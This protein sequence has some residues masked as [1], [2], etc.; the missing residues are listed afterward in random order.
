MLINTNFFQLQIQNH[1][2]GSATPIINRAKWENL[3]IPIPPIA[4]QHRIIEKIDELF[5]LCEK[6]K[7]SF[8]KSQ[9]IK[10]NLADSLV[11]KAI[12]KS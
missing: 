1:A 12:K 2:T 8:S 11:D 5:L 3:L 4:E 6:L 10:I 7:E 9:N